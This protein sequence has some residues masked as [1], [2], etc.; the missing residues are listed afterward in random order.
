MLLR[1][2]FKMGLDHLG[3]LVCYFYGIDKEMGILIG[4]GSHAVSC[5]LRPEALTEFKE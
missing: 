3:P 2:D 5:H 1:P 4:D